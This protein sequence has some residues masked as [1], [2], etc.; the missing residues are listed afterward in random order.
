M[1]D[2]PL[3]G[4]VRLSGG[5]YARAVWPGGRTLHSEPWL[6][7][8]AAAQQALIWRRQYG[9]AMRAR[10][11]GDGDACPLAAEHGRM[12]VLRR[13]DGSLLQWCPHSGHDRKPVTRSMW[14]YDHLEAAVAEYKSRP[15]ALP[16]IDAEDL[17]W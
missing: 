17:T 2:V 3:F 4:P 10:D 12:Y 13:K 16:D 8:W 1:S 9:H 6:S 11:L 15:A 14:P 5:W 7:E